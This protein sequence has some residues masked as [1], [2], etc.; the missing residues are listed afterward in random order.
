MKNRLDS[1]NT[2]ANLIELSSIVL[3]LEQGSK[4]RW[5]KALAFSSLC[6]A[7]ASSS[8]STHS[9]AIRLLEPPHRRIK[10]PLTVMSVIVPP[11]M[12]ARINSVLNAYPIVKVGLLRKIT[13]DNM[14]RDGGNGGVA[15]ATKTL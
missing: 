11:A 7:V 4:W 13:E 10:S 12:M 6:L 3:T 5:S 15:I 2:G 9:P 14:E 1:K 8:S